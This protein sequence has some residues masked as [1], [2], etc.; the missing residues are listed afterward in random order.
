ML[1]GEKDTVLQNKV[2]QSI[3]DAPP[4]RTRTSHPLKSNAIFSAER[5]GVAYG[6][7]QKKAVQ[8]RRHVSAG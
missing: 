4:N 5:K 3:I 8:I 1:D 7:I 2:A 6:S